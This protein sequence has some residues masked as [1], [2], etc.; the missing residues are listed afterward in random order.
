M[1][2]PIPQNFCQIYIVRHG[3][4]DW[5]QD[6]RLQGHANRPL[7]NDAIQQAR[8]L[9]KLLKNIEFSA[10]YSSDLIRAR[11]TAQEILLHKKTNIICKKIL[12]ERRLGVLTGKRVD[13][14]TGKLKELLYMI[15][16]NLIVSDFENHEVESKKDVQSRMIRFIKTTSLA[17][18]NTRIL[19]VTHSGLMTNL[20]LHLRYKNIKEYSHIKID[21][22]GYFIVNCNGIE[23]EVVETKGVS[24]KT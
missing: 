20:L 19:V 8:E 13:E 16:N 24:L 5:N 18:L 14:L 6:K 4:T 23:T 9:G 17:H 11:R 3:E 22:L 21:N 15:D 1:T 10:V 2:K 7:T 12:R